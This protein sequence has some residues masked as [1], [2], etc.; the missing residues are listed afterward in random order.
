MVTATESQQS[1]VLV[2]LRDMILKGTFAPGERLAEIP[3]A[4]RLNASRTPV[5]LA[6]AALE[7]EGLIEPSPGGG[8]QMRSF[9]A[10]EVAD[11]IRVRGLL[12]GFAARLLAEN[13]APRQLVRDL[14]ACLEDGDK[15]VNK[16]T[17]ELD[18]YAAY[19]E[20]N[21]RFHQLILEGC[22]NVMVKRVMETLKGQPFSAPS[23]MLPMQSSME[24]GHEWMKQAHRTH[25]AIVQAIERGQGSRAQALGEEHVEIARMNLDYALDKPELAAEIMPGIKL[26][27]GPTRSNRG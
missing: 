24:E 15:A 20:M 26:V 9:T 11:G 3:L 13:G 16:P 2:Q 4:E 17:M 5:R 25:H 22:G 19:V 23:A 10:Q 18:D 12:E 1:R 14:H 7:H 6:L 21:D 27:A 8:Y